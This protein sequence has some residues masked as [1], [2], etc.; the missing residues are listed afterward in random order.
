MKSIPVVKFYKRKY[1]EELL[2]DVTD[3]QYIKTGIIKNPVHRYNF[4][5]L[6]L[7][8]DGDEEIAINDH[9][10]RVQPG[11]LV[12]S[13]PGEIW[14]PTLSVISGDTRGIHPYNT[15]NVRIVPESDISV[16]LCDTGISTTGYTFA[17]N[18]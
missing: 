1:G 13:I 18:N 10:C 17:S 12:T 8:T 15:E 6:I 7:V 3:I 4:Y 2:I 5:S 9:K 11:T 14:H 16:F